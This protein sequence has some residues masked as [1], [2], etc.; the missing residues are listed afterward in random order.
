MLLTWF[1]GLRGQQKGRLTERR[2][3]RLTNRARPCL[4]V[5]EDRTVPATF[6]VRNLNNA[7]VDSLRWAIGQVN[8]SMDADNSIG[9]QQGLS[10]TITLTTGLDTI[11]KNVSIGTAFGGITV[12]RSSAPGTPAF[13][14]FQIAQGAEVGISTL[15]I[16]NGKTPVDVGPM[17]GGGIL[18]EGTLNLYFCTLSFNNANTS[19]GAIANEG[20]LSVENCTISSNTSANDGGGIYNNG[21]AYIQSDTQINSNQANR[22]GGGIYN[23]VG[24]TLTLTSAV[25]TFN[26][27]TLSHGGGIA[28]F[29]SLT[30]DGGVLRNNI[31]GDSGGGLYSDRGTV[32]LTN[33]SIMNNSAK[34]GGG[35]YVLDDTVTCNQCT[36]SGNTATQL[37]SGGSWFQDEDPGVLTLNNCT[38][39]GMQSFVPDT[40]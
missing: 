19:G 17:N 30:M 15:S 21:T 12:A 7:G 3:S 40:P 4:E 1:R 6:T 26:R 28:N 23:E 20:T 34:K 32:T 2:P 38:I 27:A 5:L 8:G 29:G 18:N 39:I 31:S 24:A 11:Q 9:F 13:R 36:F 10:G 35:V 16:A 37:G 22:Y 25:I 14:I 33:V